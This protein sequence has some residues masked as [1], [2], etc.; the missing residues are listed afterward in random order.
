VRDIA[1]ANT[2]GPARLP[3]RA[4]G[5]AKVGPPMAIRLPD[6]QPDHPSRRSL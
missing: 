4:N 6:G 1:P 5:L 3:S 2:N